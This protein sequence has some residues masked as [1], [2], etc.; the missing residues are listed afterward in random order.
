MSRKPRP[1]PEDTD[2]ERPEQSEP[3]SEPAP[4][5]PPAPP[6]QRAPNF[7]IEIRL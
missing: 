7:P 5:P 1:L 3:P 2:E 4:P 6:P